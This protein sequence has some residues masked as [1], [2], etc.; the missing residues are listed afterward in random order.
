MEKTTFSD[1]ER[2]AM[3]SAVKEK[4]IILIQRAINWQNNY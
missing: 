3:P 4:L 2:Q 1:L